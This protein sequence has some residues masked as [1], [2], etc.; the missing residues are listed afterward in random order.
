MDKIDK[1]VALMEDIS[2]DAEKFF[3]Q[4][5]KRSAVSARKKLQ[6]LKLAAQEMRVEIQQTKNA[7]PAAQRKK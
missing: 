1:I 7:M 5:N 2:A 3:K 6:Q 4:N